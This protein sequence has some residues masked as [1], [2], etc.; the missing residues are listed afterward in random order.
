VAIQSLLTNQIGDFAKYRS[1]LA[2]NAPFVPPFALEYLV[3]AGGGGAVANKGG[4][5]G[6]GGFRSNRVG[7]PSGGASSAEATLSIEPRINYSITIGGGGSAGGF[8]STAGV[9]SIFSTITSIGGGVANYGGRAATVGGSGA[10]GGQWGVGSLGTTGQG[11]AGGAR[12]GSYSSSGGGSGAVGGPPGSAGGVGTSSNIT[13]SSI[14]LARGGDT[15]SSVSPVENTGNGGNV[16]GNQGI[17]QSKNGGSGIVILRYPD[18]HTITIGAGLTGSTATVGSFKV[19]S[20]TAGTG[21][22]SWE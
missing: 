13:G 21:N 10:G 7:Q 19:T 1:M 4:A 2:G 22:V 9:S 15:Y 14:T 3:I 11:F 5:G 18:T 20:I 17:T 8:G 6:A 12:T 16:G